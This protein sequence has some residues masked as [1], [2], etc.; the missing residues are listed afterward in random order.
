MATKGKS[1]INLL[2]QEEFETSIV[3]K[4]LRWA[5]TTFRYIVIVTEMIVMA[6]FLSR[7]WLD[8]KN[9]DLNDILD[10]KKAQILAQGDFEKEF[11]NLQGKLQTFNE[12][13]KGTK[14][15]S[16][17]EIVAKKTPV[18]VS[19]ES[20]SF[21]K[22]K[23]DIKGLSGSEIGIAQFISNLKSDKFFKDVSLGQVNSPEDNPSLIIFNI[24]VNYQ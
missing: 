24:T 15:S 16:I 4:V 6:A 2:P 7:F 13:A 8:S 1:V 22:D 14:S 12:F 20:I 18:G 17:I 3:G 11:K 5:M 9:S 19:L 10:I 21:Q 23:V